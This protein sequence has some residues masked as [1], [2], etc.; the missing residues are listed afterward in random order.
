ME[1]REDEI[2][3]ECNQSY[4][5]KKENDE[6]FLN[7]LFTQYLSIAFSIIAIVLIFLAKFILVCGGVNASQWFEFFAFTFIAIALVIELV[8][9]VKNGKV[10]WKSS[11]LPVFGIAL[12]FI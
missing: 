2:I 4:S 9:V 7:K 10:D 8:K 5:N 3:I 12:I 6:P 11:M 1:E